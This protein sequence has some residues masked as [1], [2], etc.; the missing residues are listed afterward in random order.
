[1]EP[2]RTIVV[3]SGAGG[4]S[5]A[6]LLAK[7]GRRV[8]VIESQPEI[9][10][11]L[12][13]FT[14][15]RMRFDTGYHF[16]G[17]Y[18]NTM[19]MILH[20]LGL[21]DA[22]RA[23]PIPNRIILRNSEHDLTIPAESGFRGSEAIMCDCFKEDASALHALFDAIHTV[24]HNSPVHDFRDL[25]PPRLEISVYDIQSVAEFYRSIGIGSAA[26]A[27]AGSL[28]M[29]HGSLPSEA[30]MSF[31]AR[32]GYA[33]FDDLARPVGGGD[34]IIAGF[35]REAARLGIELRTGTTLLPFSEMN[36]DGECSTVRLSDGSVIEADQVFFTIHPS[37][38]SA[39]LP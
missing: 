23:E 18:T 13:R 30:A 1:M 12:R 20:I 14:R 9:G 7:A 22:N 15:E 26:G 6:L 24:W 39:L 32:V 4:I 28:A 2:K 27:A 29:C 19:S 5:L 10:G 33:I 34:P 21:D 25:T 11:Y 3:G 16:S 17:G 36:A 31:H 38:V 35:R 8:T 37:S